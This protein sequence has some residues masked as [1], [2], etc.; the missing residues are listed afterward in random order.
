MIYSHYGSTCEWFNS[1]TTESR[2]LGAVLSLSV[3]T[4]KS[5]IE[6][7]YGAGLELFKIP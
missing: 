2:V 1:V 6:S 4:K 5:K 3:S 7:S